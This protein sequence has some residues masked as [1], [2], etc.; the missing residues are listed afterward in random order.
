MA[1]GVEPPDYYRPYIDPLTKA[2]RTKQCPANEPLAS[3][4]CDFTGYYPGSINNP[5]EPLVEIKVQSGPADP[6]NPDY[7]A[8]PCTDGASWRCWFQPEAI[9][10]GPS[11]GGAQA[12]ASWIS[13]CGPEGGQSLLIIPGETILYAGSGAGNMQA[14]VL[15]E[16]KDLIDAT[17]DEVV[18]DAD[19]E[20]PSVGFQLF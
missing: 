2:P 6:M 15:D 18:W 4:G 9:N 10:G 12:L 20:P 17:F 5:D 7:V 14:L 8:S 3:D 11:G 1:T 19:H 16:F 13:G